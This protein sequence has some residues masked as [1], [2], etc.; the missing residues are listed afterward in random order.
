[1]LNYIRAELYRL[2]RRPGL[3]VTT[4]VLCA[5][6]IAFNCFLAFFDWEAY[7]TDRSTSLIAGQSL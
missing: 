1:M 5:A 7:G 2:F 6:P 3:Y 4:L